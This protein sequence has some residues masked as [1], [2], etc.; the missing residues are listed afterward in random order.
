MLDK[1]KYDISVLPM[2]YQGPVKDRY[3][4]INI[5]PEQILLSA[6]RGR[7]E[8]ENKTYRKVLFFFIKAIVNLSRKLHLDVSD[9]LYGYVAK[10]V[11]KKYKFDI[12]INGN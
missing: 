9:T 10:R 2:T 4:G 11:Q 8:K 1:E 6:M 12:T 7:I 5:L 3:T